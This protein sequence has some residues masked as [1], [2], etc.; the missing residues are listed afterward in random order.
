[1]TRT[2][3]TL[4]TPLMLNHLIQT[5]FNLTDAFWVSRL[6]DV[7][8]AAVALVWPVIF[9]MIA[10][11]IGLSVAGTALVSQY[12]GAGDVENAGQAAGQVLVFCLLF[13]VLAGA[14]GFLLT[15]SILWWMGGR[16]ELYAQA[17]TFLRISFLAM[18]LLFGFQAYSCIHQGQGDTVSPMLFGVASVALNMILDPIAILVLHMGVGG[19]A[20]AT[21]VSQLIFY[22]I[23]VVTLLGRRNRGFTIRRQNLKPRWEWLKRFAKIGMP[24]SIGQSSEG[25]GFIIMNAL[26]VGYGDNTMAAVGIGNRINSIVQMPAMGIGSALTSIVGQNI[27]YGDIVRVGLAVRRSLRI[28]VSFSLLGGLILY[29]LAGKVM[30]AFTDSPEVYA[31]GVTYLR[32]LCAG[33]FLMAIHQ[34][35][36]G[37]FSGSGHTTLTMIVMVGRIIL[38]RIPLVMLLDHG[39][40]LGSA[41]VWYSMVLSN[42]ISCLVGAGLYWSGRWKHAVIHSS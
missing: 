13:S 22:S 35:F 4:A 33:I 3:L 8:V 17:V 26:I 6:G 18:P 21:L 20:W 9:F 1:M 39:F 41:S 38:V 2:V 36:I 40:G 10:L 16:G 24:A 12:I 15:P 37:V 31:I 14:A 23:A 7:S 30:E 5:I 19:A 29:L 34:T 11:G 42:A 28:S 27:G 32:W 25:I